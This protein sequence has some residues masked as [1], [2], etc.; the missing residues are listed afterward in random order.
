MRPNIT[1][2]DLGLH[3][4]RKRSFHFSIRQI[5]SKAW[6]LLLINKSRPI[7]LD[8]YPKIPIFLVLN[9]VIELQ[10]PF[11]TWSM[12]FI[13]RKLVIRYIIHVHYSKWT[14]I[15]YSLKHFILKLY[16][17]EHSSF[18]CEALRL[19]DQSNTSENVTYM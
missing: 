17:F 13:S 8:E 1:D 15:R 12:M 5:S 16:T 9:T 3:T 10:K 2:S 4:S 11:K 18:T 6:W 7:G 19:E 14:T